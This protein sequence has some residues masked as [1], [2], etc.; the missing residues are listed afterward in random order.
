MKIAIPVSAGRLCPHFGHCE[1]FALIEIDQTTGQP[2]QPKYLTPPPHEPGVL[3]GW[4]H[5][6]G[7]D[8]IIAGGMGQRAQQLFSQ[9]G[10]QVV[11][12]VES[13]T[14]LELAT[15]YCHG[16]LAP[17]QNPCDH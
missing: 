4:L 16:A 13:N 7:A 2:N 10:I 3:P 14:P 17:G 12:G 5:E 11:V 1:Q 15:A 9:H 8:V 6:Q